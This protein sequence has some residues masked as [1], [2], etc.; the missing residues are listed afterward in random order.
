[1]KALSLRNP[2]AWLLLRPD[3]TDP[4]ERDIARS[5][6]RI[7]DIENRDWHTKE[8]GWV[9]VH[10]SA[11]MTR[12][13]YETAQIHAD[14]LA[15]E[16]PPFADLPRGGIVGAFFI[17][18]CVP[19]HSSPWFFGDFGFVITQ[20]RPLPFTPCK[21]K[22]GFFT[23]DV[24]ADLFRVEQ[25]AQD[26]PIFRSEHD[27]PPCSAAQAIALVNI[28]ERGGNYTRFVGGTWLPEGGD[29]L[30]SGVKE[31]LRATDR[32]ITSLIRN[33]YLTVKQELNGHPVRV[34]L[35]FP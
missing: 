3:I 23:P 4:A 33:G 32:T 24:S 34:A 26:L 11:T 28:K 35:T 14:S 6:H 2:W 15:I 17:S 31:V 9:L 21:G 20:S 27:L 25:E 7:K 29:C 22:L 30:G 16:L 5:S 8:R 12:G 10:A 19:G 1:M 13:D 18:A